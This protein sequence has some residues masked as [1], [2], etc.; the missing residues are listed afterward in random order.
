MN[1][2]K[3]ELLPPCEYGFGIIFLWCKEGKGISIS[4]IKYVLFIGVVYE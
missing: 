4:L 2:V 3:C 1:L